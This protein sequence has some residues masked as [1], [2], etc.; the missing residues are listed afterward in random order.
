MGHGRAGKAAGRWARG[1]TLIELLV[2]IAI[3]AILAAMLLPALAKA[4]REALKT[5]CK[6]NLKQLGVVSYN[7]AMD[8]KDNFPN[9]NPSYDADPY[10]PHGNWPWDVPDYVANML[11]GNGT[12]PDLCYCPANPTL[13]KAIYWDYNN[14]GNGDISTANTYRV[15][16]YVFAFTNT[17]CVYYTNITESLRPSGYT[18]PV[19]GGSLTVNPP[20]SQRV[21]IADAINSND[22][23]GTKAQNVYVHCHD[24][25]NPPYYTDSSHLNGHIPDGNNLL[26]AD[27]HVDWRP[28]MDPT[29]VVRSSSDY[30][31][32][33]IGPAD[34]V[35][36]FWW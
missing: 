11:A 8:N 16:G 28:F 32:T 15:L 6:S 13:T 4:K 2:V 29:L 10:D 23:G 31:G 1:F 12:T 30:A 19:E 20:L 33:T 24:G 26:F 25:V 36:Y 9:M 14:S 17:G 34:G 27:S 22:D 5:Q 3:I 7:Y 18:V 21:I 35:M